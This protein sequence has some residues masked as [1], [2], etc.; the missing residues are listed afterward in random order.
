MRIIRKLTLAAALG[1]MVVTGVAIGQ[2]AGAAPASRSSTTVH[3]VTVR[4]VDFH[5]LDFRVHPQHVENTGGGVYAQV[6]PGPNV[7]N[8]IYLEA[9]P[10]LPVGA[11]L[12]D[13]TFYYR[14]CG[15]GSSHAPL[16]RFYVF[17][18]EPSKATGTYL[19]PQQASPVVRCDV[20]VSFPFTF[21]PPVKVA[22]GKVY[23]VGIE[24][25]FSVLGPTPETELALIDL[26]IEGAKVRYTCPNGC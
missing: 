1:A 13:V 10:P 20:T 3:S 24:S 23:A 7:P 21:N 22:A 12:K 19:M 9:D 17:A 2:I 15:S 11:V 5:G 18:Y 8:H 4:G 25:L 14:D 6:Y 26:L 16:G